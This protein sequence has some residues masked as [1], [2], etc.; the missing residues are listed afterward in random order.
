MEPIDV[1]CIIYID[2]GLENNDEDPKFKVC[3]HV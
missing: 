2:S 1:K 3:D